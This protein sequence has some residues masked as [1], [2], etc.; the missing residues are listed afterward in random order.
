[1]LSTCW[2]LSMTTFRLFTGSPLSCSRPRCRRIRSSSPGRN[3]RWFDTLWSPPANS[4]RL[5]SPS[6]C[7]F[8][9]WQCSWDR[10]T[11]RCRACRSWCPPWWRRPWSHK[12]LFSLFY[13]FSYS[14]RPTLRFQHG[15][16]TGFWGCNVWLYTT[17]MTGFCKWVRF[18]CSM[19]HCTCVAHSFARLP[20][21]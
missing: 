13:F 12:I 6:P 5:F 4:S 16:K 14:N 19:A 20:F 18:P 1:M 8:C 17:S 3:T 2:V 15:P 7:G 11:F 21:A 9:S 10:R